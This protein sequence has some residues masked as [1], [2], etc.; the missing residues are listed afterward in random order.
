MDPDYYMGTDDVYAKF[1][2][3][4]IAELRQHWNDLIYGNGHW[5]EGET[6]SIWL[7][8]EKNMILCGGA[9]D[10]DDIESIEQALGGI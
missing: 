8:G 10:Q 9:F 1:F 7:C 6:Y 3:N 4:D 5:F 2:F